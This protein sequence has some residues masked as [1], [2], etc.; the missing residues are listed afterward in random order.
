MEYTNINTI[1]A[2]LTRHP[3][4]E[5]ISM[6]TII[7]YAVEFIRIMG[8]PNTFIEK[9]VPIEIKEFRGELPCDLYEVIQVRYKDRIFRESTDSFHMSHDKIP[10]ELSYKMNDNCIFTSLEEGTIE[11]A[12]KAMPTDMNGYPLIPDNGSYE[13]ALEAYI[14]LQW[15]TML[16]DLGKVLPVVLQNT[17]REY[18]TAVTRAYTGLLMPSLDKMEN[19]AR[20]WNRM[21]PDRPFDHI[22]GYKNMSDK[23]ILKVH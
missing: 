2:K 4:M 9:V 22:T 6:E 10:G 23:E 20:L 5:D 7:D 17:Q 12:Y 18:H 21:L 19:I 15:F 3:L 16:F 1:A 13:K 11:M 14:K 8:I